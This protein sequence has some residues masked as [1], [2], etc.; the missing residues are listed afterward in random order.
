MKLTSD[1]AQNFEKGLLHVGSHL[2]GHR[3]SESICL[4]HIKNNTGSPW[5]CRN[6]LENLAITSALMA[7]FA[8]RDLARCKQ[9]AYVAAKLSRNLYQIAPLTG[10]YSPG[11][12]FNDLLMP[13]LSDHPPLVAWFGFFDGIDVNRAVKGGTGEFRTYQAKLALRGEWDALAERSERWLSNVPER[14]KRFAPDNR[15]HLALARGDVAAM[16]NALAEMVTPKQVLWRNEHH[17]Y[18]G[19]FIVQE[20]VVY[21]KIAWR[22]GFQVQVD[23]PWIPKEWLPVEPLSHYEDPY[24]FMKSFDIDAPVPHVPIPR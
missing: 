18:T 19:W 22:H 1:Y 16:E 12:P 13:L 2:E 6:G 8:N 9:W 21:A 15:F 4:T 23:T 11:V 3:E 10:I 24:S 5:G 14:M 20:A 17:G 7:W